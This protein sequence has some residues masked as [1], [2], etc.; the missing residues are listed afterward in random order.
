MLLYPVVKFIL[1]YRMIASDYDLQR[2]EYLHFGSS[3]PS[4]MGILHRYLPVTSW[5]SWIILQLGNGEFWVKFSLLC[6]GVLTILLVL[7]KH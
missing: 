4:G 6:F 5:F 1:Q 2:D 3:A 7:E